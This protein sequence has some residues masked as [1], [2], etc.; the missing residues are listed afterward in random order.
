MTICRM[1]EPRPILRVTVFHGHLNILDGAF[2]QGEQ[3]IRMIE[4]LDPPLICQY[5]E[6]MRWIRNESQSARLVVVMVEVMKRSDL[7]YIRWMKCTLRDQ[8]AIMYN[9]NVVRD[10]AEA[11][12]LKVLQWLCENDNDMSSTVA[13]C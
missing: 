6:I 4:S 8:D 3:S 5:P 9:H 10:A 11:G 7:D 13:L 1:Q 2:Y 12:Q